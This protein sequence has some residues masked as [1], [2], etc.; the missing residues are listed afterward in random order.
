VQSVSAW[1]RFVLRRLL[2]LALITLCLLLASFSIVRL[3]PGDPA[4]KLSGLAANGATIAQMEHQLGLDRSYWS[5]F[6]SYV[7]GVA[8]GDLGNGFATRE[9]VTKIIAQNAGYSFRLAGVSFVVVLLMGSV[10]G[11]TSAWLTHGGSRRWFELGFTTT[12]GVLGAVPEYLLATVLTAIFAVWLAWLPV[13]GTG[14]NGIVLPVLALSLP[15]G[16]VLM[17]I[18]R[19]ETLNVLSQDYVRT[20]EAKRLPTSL[21]YRRHVLPNVLTAALTYAGVLFATLIGG[22][23]VVENVFARPGLGSIIVNAVTVGD[24]PVIQAIILLL[25]MTVAIVNAAVDVILS[26]LD[27][28][29]N[30][31]HA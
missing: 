12:T 8:S 31:R 18:V 27:P 2:G 28:R 7:R 9:P 5:Q 3:I 19:A 21:I 10:G 22:A 23:V 26:M 13:A 1:A 11:L 16:F 24:Y 29:S 25:G 17:R 4:Q 6:A 20:A 15:T 30:V 14:T